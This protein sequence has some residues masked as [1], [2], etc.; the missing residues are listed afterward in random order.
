MFKRTPGETLASVLDDAAARGDDMKLLRLS[1]TW[2][3]RA[4]GGFEAW[5]F[6]STAASAMETSA[7]SLRFV[8]MG[9][10]ADLLDGWATE[11]LE[12]RSEIEAAYGDHLDASLTEAKSLALG[13]L[14][15]IS[16]LGKKT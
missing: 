7:W 4:R 3:R 6:A 2:G 8:G 12:I 5:S 16:E 10:M 1:K 13:T 11:L 9:K 15:Y 14:L